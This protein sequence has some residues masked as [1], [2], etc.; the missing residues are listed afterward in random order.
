MMCFAGD[1]VLIAGNELMEFIRR[2][3]IVSLEFGLKINN[4]K[5]KIMSLDRDS[6][7]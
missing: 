1:T 5:T 4:N 3:E 2:L 7:N 6:E